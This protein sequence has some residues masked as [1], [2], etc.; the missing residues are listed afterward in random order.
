M[1]L[2]ETDIEI[3]KIFD[4]ACS[5]MM[6]FELRNFFSWFLIS[7]KILTT[8]SI[9][10][11]YKLFFCEDFKNDIENRALQEN[12][13]VLTLENMSCST[14]YHNRKSYNHIRTII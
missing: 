8:T 2:I 1:G 14:L 11:K 4:E 9:W 5:I 13:N 3:H 10:E 12:N 7:N 6:P